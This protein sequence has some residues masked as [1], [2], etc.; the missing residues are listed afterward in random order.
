MALL[1]F[2]I[3]T[4]LAILAAEKQQRVP[5]PQHHILYLGNEDR[6]ISG[7][8]NRL[9]AT[10]EIGQRPMKDRGSVAGAVKSCACFSFGVLVAS[11]RTSIVFRDGPLIFTENV[12]SETLLGMQV[13]V[14]PGAV[15]HAN[16]HEHGIQRNRSEGVGRHAVNF[17]I[18]VYGDD[19]DPG[20]EGT[21]AFAEFCLA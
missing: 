18:E 1:V 20:G 8:L 5:I 19:R 21:H 11:L 2:H 16:Q 3:L 13:G 10:L 15:V 9:Q 12:N 6:V 4:D 7:L 17:A 14:G